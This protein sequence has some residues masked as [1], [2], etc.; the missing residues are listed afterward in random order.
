MPPPTSTF[1]SLPTEL[2]LQIYSLLLHGNHGYCHLE[3]RKTP[4]TYL[5]PRLYPAILAVNRSISADAYPIL[6]GDNTF[7]FLGTTTGADQLH[8]QYQTL[9]RLAGL[10]KLQTPSL[11]PERSR[12]LIKHVAIAPLELTKNDWVDK[13][14]ELSLMTKTIEF[15]LWVGLFRRPYLL[16]PLASI[17]TLNASIPAIKRLINASTQTFRIGTL[18]KSTNFDYTFRYPCRKREELSGMQLVVVDLKGLDDVSEKSQIVH[19]ALNFII[20]IMSQ[21]PLLPNDT[22]PPGQTL[23]SVGK[24]LLVHKDFADFWSS[25]DFTVPGESQGWSPVDRNGQSVEIGQECRIITWRRS[26][27][28]DAQNKQSLYSG[29]RPS[30]AEAILAWR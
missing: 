15:D 29:Y 14:L 4:R 6:Y 12:H 25:D 18:Y 30:A 7:L 28:S 10:P 8:V 19:K 26:G 20:K 22:I 17:P 3:K 27:T 9:G 1:E 5:I 24:R 16:E 11:L 13:L 21:R 2:R 23:V